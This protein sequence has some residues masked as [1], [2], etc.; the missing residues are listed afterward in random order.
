M[1]NPEDGFGAVERFLLRLSLLV[2]LLLGL[3]RVLGSEVK[4]LLNEWDGQK[5]QATSTVSH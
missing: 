3:V 5:V 1:A 4:I 2:L